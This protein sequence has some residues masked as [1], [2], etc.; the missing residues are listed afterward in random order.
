MKKFIGGVAAI[1]TTAALV[2]ALAF[3]A[4]IPYMTGPGGSNPAVFPA[5]IPDINDTIQA[6]NSG[7]TVQ[8][9]ATYT[10]FRNVL[11]NGAFLVAQRGTAATAGGQQSGVVSLN[12]SADR[13]VVDTNVA[14]GAGYSQ[15]VTAS[16]SP[17]SNFQNSLKVYR[18][19]GALLQ[20]V[21][22][23]QEVATGGSIP[24]AGQSV[25]VSSYLQAL[26]G[27]TATGSTVTVKLLGGTGADEGLKSAFTTAPATTPAWTGISTIS[28]QDFTTTTGWVRYSTTPIFIP[29]TVTELAVQ[30]CFT[31]V[32]SSSG[33]TDGFAI[34]GVQMEQSNSIASSFEFRESSAETAKL[35]RY[36][37]QYAD[38]ATT[39]RYPGFCT[40]NVSATSALCSIFLPVTMRVA[41]TVVVTTSNSF[42]MTKVADGTAEACTTLVLTATSATQQAFSVLCSVSETAAVGTGHQFIGG[43]SGVGNTITVSA[44]F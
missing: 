4:N 39:L 42:G 30:Y 38:G 5:D 35:Q 3:A 41:P 10:N 9:T 37:V 34:T 19:S 23:M 17:P 1:V 13:W 33:A 7:I 31:P 26:A 20:P 44:D 11:D 6:I 18:N 25:V 16:P 43:N 22:V 27:F 2:S 32:G 28:S 12:Y 15:V 36:Y 8:S 29:S 21:C 14:S 40:E 24:L